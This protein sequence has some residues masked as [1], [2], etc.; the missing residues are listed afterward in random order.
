VIESVDQDIKIGMDDCE[1]LLLEKT[2]ISAATCLWRKG[3]GVSFLLVL[4]V[5]PPVCHCSWDMAVCA[6]WLCLW[7][8]I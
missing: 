6:F 4:A 1:A 8:K 5:A 3:E 2:K 7:A